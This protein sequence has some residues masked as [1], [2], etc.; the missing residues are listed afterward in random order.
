MSFFK[1]TLIII[2]LSFNIYAKENKT[3]SLTNTNEIYF[4][5]KEADL[6]KDNILRLIKKSKKSILIAMYNFSY[7]KFAK[8]LVTSAKDGVKITIIL[9]KSKV[10]K[11]D[12][13]YKYLKSNGINVKIANKKMHLKIALFDENIAILGSTN[14]TKESFKD[15]YEVVLFT[16]DKKVINKI[17]DSLNK[18]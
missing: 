1:I 15:N 5:P 2:F 10:D 6:A 3:F 11:K 8:E 18:F 13:I 17:Q 7:K 9:D 4:L 16:R 14:W 12:K